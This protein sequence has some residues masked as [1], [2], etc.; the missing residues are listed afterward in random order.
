MGR[1]LGRIEGRLFSESG[2]LFLVV[3]T[4]E[5]AGMARVT[6]RLGEQTE[7]LE[8]PFSEVARRISASPA[9][10]LDN[11]NGPGSAKRILEGENGWYFETREGR[12]GPFGSR[13]EAGRELV[14]YVLSMQTAG[15]S[16]EEALRAAA[17]LQ[18]W[19]RS[20]DLEAL[21]YSNST[22]G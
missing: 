14:R 3:R 5:A 10:I 6:C 11:L 12:M 7:V 2:C 20:P 17:R 13:E 9:L 18:M 4:D 16:R 21:G 8:L 15:S 1:S 22:M 19:E